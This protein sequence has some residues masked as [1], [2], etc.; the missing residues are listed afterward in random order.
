MAINEAKYPAALSYG[1]NVK[2]TQLQA[3]VAAQNGR[4]D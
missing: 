3:E 2:Y 1:R 4:R